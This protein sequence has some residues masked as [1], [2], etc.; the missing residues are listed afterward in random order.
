MTLIGS[1]AIAE[2]DTI[3]MQW[4]QSVTFWLGASIFSQIVREGAFWVC[5]RLASWVW[6]HWDT[7]R[8]PILYSFFLLIVPCGN[9]GKVVQF[10]GPCPHLTRLFS[11]LCF[12]LG[13]HGNLWISCAELTGSLS[14]HLFFMKLNWKTPVCCILSLSLGCKNDWV[15]LLSFLSPQTSTR[16]WLAQGQQ[17]SGL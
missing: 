4:G 15:R 10:P 3:C 16:S 13:C 8:N 7:Y 1:W 6:C 2:P 14:T 12:S 11:F 9:W 5:T 17:V